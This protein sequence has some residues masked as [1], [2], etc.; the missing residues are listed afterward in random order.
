M[1]GSYPAERNQSPTSSDTQSISSNS[2][3]KNTKEGSSSEAPPPDDEKKG[4]IPGPPE[5]PT[6]TK[7]HDLNGDLIPLEDRKSERK[8]GKIQLREDDAW[9]ELGFSYPV[10]SDFVAGNRN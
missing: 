7:T 2:N 4:G 10:S 5:E 9:E 1:S 6:A 3:P 8:D